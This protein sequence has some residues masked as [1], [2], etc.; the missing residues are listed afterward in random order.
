MARI[1][2]VDDLRGNTTSNDITVTVGSL[3]NMLF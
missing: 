3:S 2:K 1:L